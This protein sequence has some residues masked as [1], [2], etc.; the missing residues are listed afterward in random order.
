MYGPKRHYTE[1]S[2]RTGSVEFA[3]PGPRAE[4]IKLA[5]K[6]RTRLEELV[7]AHSTPQQI[8]LRARIILLYSQGLNYAEVARELS[9]WR[10]TAR[11]WVHR[12]RGLGEG[13]SVEARLA[14]AERSGCPGTFTPEQIVAI[15]AIG[16]EVLDGGNGC[17]GPRTQQ[18]VANEGIKRGIFKSISPDTVGRFFKRSRPQAA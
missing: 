8:V 5:D 10:N 6:E 7:R 16:C 17:S 15:V 4:S 9:C 3:V 11:H 1:I 2:S 13:Q 12:W 18:E 14:D